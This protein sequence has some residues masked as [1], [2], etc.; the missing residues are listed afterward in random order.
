M[1]AGARFKKTLDYGLKRGTV[2][3]SS[4]MLRLPES[5]LLSGD[6][7]PYSTCNSICH[8]EKILP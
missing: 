7:L 6:R 8:L 2:G 1:R 4:C 5:A 3:C